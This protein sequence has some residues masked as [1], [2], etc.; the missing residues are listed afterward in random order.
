MLNKTFTHKATDTLR[1]FP[2]GLPDGSIL[3]TKDEGVPTNM[4]VAQG[5]KLGVVDRIRPGMDREISFYG[6]TKL[7]N[8]QRLISVSDGHS[9]RFY[10][11]ENDKKI[12]YLVEQPSRSHEESW[13]NLFKGLLL[14]DSDR[15]NV[16]FTICRPF[17]GQFFKM[18][19]QESVRITLSGKWKGQLVHM[20]VEHYSVM[21][22]NLIQINLNGQDHFMK[23]D[24][25][26]LKE[27]LG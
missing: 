22:D 14:D 19:N 11:F 9:T 25:H 26:P 12:S 1:N 17:F 7:E 4:N 6:V 15:G 8:G 20:E 18:Q 27:L 24:F 5:Q 2:F 21:G 10:W 13:M 23:L 3:I 16:M